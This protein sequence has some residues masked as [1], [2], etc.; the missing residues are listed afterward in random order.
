[1][2][3]S[4]IEISLLS[5][6]FVSNISRQWAATYVLL[7]IA[8]D[9]TI[10]NRPNDVD[11]LYEGLIAIVNLVS[12]DEGQET[13]GVEAETAL[14]SHMNYLYMYA[15]RN[16]AYNDTRR[17]M[18]RRI[19]DFTIRFFPDLTNFVNNLDWPD[20]CIP[21]YWAELSEEAHTDTSGWNVCS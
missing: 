20:E 16:Y 18:V 17:E 11:H 13:L 3:M 21:Y 6:P 7:A 15:R 12:S 9:A 14:L 8:F 4:V 1:M 19:N 5:P 2:S 10:S